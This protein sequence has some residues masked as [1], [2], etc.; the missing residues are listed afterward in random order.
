M[1]EKFNK[2]AIRQTSSIQLR[3]TKRRRIFWYERCDDQM[4]EMKCVEC[5]IDNKY[6]RIMN[7]E[8][9]TKKLRKIISLICYSDNES[10][11]ISLGKIIQ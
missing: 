5:V 8:N 4:P 6:V 11:V 9:L 3:M 10:K 7:Y 2:M 1:V